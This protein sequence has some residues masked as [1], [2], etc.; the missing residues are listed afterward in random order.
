M[1]CRLQVILTR[2]RKEPALGQEVIILLSKPPAALQESSSQGGTPE[3]CSSG[4][5]RKYMQCTST[6]AHK[7]DGTL[8]RK[9]EVIIRDNQAF[10]LLML[11]EKAVYGNEGW[12]GE[13][14]CDCSRL[15]IH[16][17]APW[18]L[19]QKRI[20]GAVNTHLKRIYN[21]DSLLGGLSTCFMT[22]TIRRDIS[23]L[24][25]TLISVKTPLFLF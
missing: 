13:L 20:T 11:K 25:G 2:A 15:I 14:A 18:S 10:T 3:G 7:S 9:A 17:I 4:P 23:I 12:G 16:R 21:S 24:C 6:Q 22:G 8:A 19:L 5:I 1:L